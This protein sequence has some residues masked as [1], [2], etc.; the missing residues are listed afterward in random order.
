MSECLLVT[1]IGSLVEAKIDLGVSV[2]LRRWN[3]VFR[4]PKV[5]VKSFEAFCNVK[6]LSLSGHTSSVSW[7]FPVLD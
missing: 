5:V 4:Y 7:P 1:D 2:G 3:N 6:F